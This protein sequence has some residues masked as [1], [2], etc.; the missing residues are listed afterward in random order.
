LSYFY[1]KDKR[2]F[3]ILQTSTHKLHFVKSVAASP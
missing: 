3:K 2:S 1:I